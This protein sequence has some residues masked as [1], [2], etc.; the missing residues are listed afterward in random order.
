MWFCYV[1]LDV[2]YVV[3]VYGVFVYDCY[4]G[5]YIEMLLIFIYLFEIFIMGSYKIYEIL[6]GS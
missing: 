3:I 4:I 6:D 1:N 2:K 5:K